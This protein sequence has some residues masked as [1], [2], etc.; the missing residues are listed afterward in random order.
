V[1]IFFFLSLFTKGHFVF[2]RD[3]HDGHDGSSG[4]DGGGGGFP[5]L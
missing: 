5:L 3:G 4:S 2:N 1:Y